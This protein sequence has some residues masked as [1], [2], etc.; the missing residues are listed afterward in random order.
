M[1]QEYIPVMLEASSGRNGLQA[2]QASSFLPVGLLNSFAGYALTRKNTA[3]YCHP[4]GIYLAA[5]PSGN[6]QK[7]FIAF[8][9]PAK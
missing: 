2:K 4:G 8:Y 7:P 3:P 6:K 5:C 1:L 9:S